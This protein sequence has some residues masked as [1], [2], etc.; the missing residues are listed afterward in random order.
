[1]FVQNNTIFYKTKTFGKKIIFRF[2]V[3]TL[4]M[5]DFF[6]RNEINIFKLSIVCT[7]QRRNKERKQ[8]KLGRYCLL[9]METF[10]IHFQLFKKVVK[11]QKKYKNNC[12]MN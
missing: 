3:L 4:N 12:T 9:V 8:V 1:L 6:S 10:S 11:R 2:R 7:F 5:N